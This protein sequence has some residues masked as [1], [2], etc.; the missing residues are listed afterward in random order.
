MPFG[1]TATRDGNQVRFQLAVQL[2]RPARPWIVFDG[3]L[4]FSLD[5]S[6]ARSGNGGGVDQKHADRLI[7]P[8]SFVRFEQ[9]QDCLAVRTGGL[10][11]WETSSR[12]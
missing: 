5:E 2:A 4:K 3:T 12:R 7:F 1:R 6:L 8:M 10:P 11:R 9:L